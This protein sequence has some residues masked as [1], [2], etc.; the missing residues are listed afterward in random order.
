MAAIKK[1]EAQ[2]IVESPDDRIKPEGSDKKS[3]V[4]AKLHKNTKEENTQPEIPPAKTAETSKISIEEPSEPKSKLK[5]FA[6]LII[7]FVEYIKKR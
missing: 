3:E 6:G 7:G 1:A 2:E 4:L 5:L